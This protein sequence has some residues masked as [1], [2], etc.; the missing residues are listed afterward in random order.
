L[1]PHGTPPQQIQAAQA[2]VDKVAKELQDIESKKKK[3]E[4]DFHKLNEQK[5][6]LEKGDVESYHKN[7]EKFFAKE[8]EAIQKLPDVPKT[9][10]VSVAVMGFTSAGK[11]SLLNNVF[12]L[13]LKV[14]AIRCTDG[15]EMVGEKDGIQVYDVFGENN[16]QSY[17]NMQLLMRAKTIHTIIV[18]YTDC[19][20]TSL[21]MVQLVNALQVNTVYFRNKSEDLDEDEVKLVMDHDGKRIKEK[22]G[23]LKR[24]IVGSAKTG[25]GCDELLGVL[26]GKA[27]SEV[28]L[29]PAAKR[30]KVESPPAMSAP[31]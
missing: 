27:E 6:Q 4:A 24:V 11:S 28:S 31:H 8:L 7:M 29:S 2:Q 22:T 19:I 1:M 12:G 9:A 18:V 16:E 25:M 10:K 23:K 21:Q 3:A 13:K 20:D 5:K 15:A 17:H 30:R 26:T 14:S